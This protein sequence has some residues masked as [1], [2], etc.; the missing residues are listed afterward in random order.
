MRRAAHQFV[1]SEPLI[2]RDPFAVRVL[3]ASTV[4]E[5]KRTPDAER[6][7]Y[8]AAMRSWVTA[9]ARVAEDSLH[10]AVRELAAA[11]YLVLGAGLDTFALRNPYPQVEVFEVDFPATQAWKRERLAHAGLAVRE[12]AHFVSVDFERQSLGEELLGAGFSFSRPTVTAWLGV[13]MYLTAPAFAS[14]CRMLGQLP[15]GS[16]VV[17]DYSQP[18]EVL[19]TVGQQL[20]DSLAAQVAQ[21]GEPFQL[22]FTPESLAEE[23]MRHGLAVA[24]DWSGADLNA[25]FFSQ[26]DDGLGLRGSGAHLCRAIVP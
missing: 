5:L 26:R 21:A 18:L 4:E 23:L 10:G 19:P 6:K 16:A 14:T 9:R 20:H 12:T 25:L 3:D 1:D 2:F 7:P 17:F 8:S 22:Y 11:Q 24:S 13:T 15:S